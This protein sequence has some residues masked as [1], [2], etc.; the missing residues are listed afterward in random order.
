MDRE[1]LILYQRRLL[2]T[3]YFASV[4]AEN[5]PAAPQWAERA[6]LRSR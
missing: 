3:G 5:R 4:Q 6:P 1:K 2:E